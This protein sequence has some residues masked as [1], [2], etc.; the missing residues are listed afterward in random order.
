MLPPEFGRVTVIV[1]LI[2][3]GVE[4]RV[5]LTVPKLI[6]EVIFLNK[7]LNALEFND[8][9]VRR[10]ADKPAGKRGL[11]QNADLVDIAHEI[12]I[13]RPHTPPTVG[14]EDDEALSPEQLQRLADW[15]CGRPMPLGEVGDDQ[16]FVGLEA[17]FDDVVPDELINGR[18]LR[19]GASR[20]DAHGRLGFEIRHRPCPF[21]SRATL[22]TSSSVSVK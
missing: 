7:A 16:T 12:L 14:G 13:D 6:S 21:D 1:A 3:H 22:L 15:I 5:E 17:A 18:P 10:H 8:V 2:H 9:F 19:R 4:C 20:I 11:D